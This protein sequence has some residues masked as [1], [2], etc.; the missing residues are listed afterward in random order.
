[1]SASASMALQW[2]TLGEICRQLKDPTRNGEH[3]LADHQAAPGSG[4]LHAEM[5]LHQEE[6][7]DVVEIGH[8][9]GLTAGAVK[10]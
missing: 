7:H 1:M 6:D 2:L 4:H 9:S 5:A 8:A 10:G 3:S